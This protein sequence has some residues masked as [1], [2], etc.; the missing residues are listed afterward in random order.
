MLPL[1]PYRLG[2]RDEPINHLF[3]RIIKEVGR[4][5]D[6]GDVDD[7][8]DD[9]EAEGLR[10]SLD[11]L[12]CLLEDGIEIL[13]ESANDKWRVVSE[14][15][16]SV[17]G[18]E[19]VVLF[20]QPIETVTALAD[21]LDQKSGRRPAL[22]I[23]GQSDSERQAEVDAFRRP[24][25]PQF[26]VSSRA[27]GEGINLQVA[28]RLVHID[29]PWNPMDMEQRVGRVHR[30]GSRKTILVDTLVV[31]D[32]R[33]ADAYRISRQKLHLI[34][35]TLVAKD[36]FEQVFSRVMCL[37]PPEELQDVLL[38][39]PQ[40]PFN[41][42]EQERI[43]EMVQR[44]FH[45][46]RAFH[47]RFGMQ[48]REMRKQTP[49][50]MTWNDVKDFACDYLNAEKVDGFKRQRFRAS[51]GQVDAVEEDAVVLKL[52]SGQIVAC[53][54]AGGVPVYGP[55][56]S[57]APSVGLN[58]PPF[59]E[60]LRR[61]AFPRTPSGAAHLRW[62]EHIPAIWALP[63][64]VL[65]FLRQTIKAHHHGGWL[66]QG[67]CLFTYVLRIPSTVDLVEGPQKGQLMR[68]LFKATIRAKPGQDS[69]LM[70]LLRDQQANLVQQ[71]RRP[72]ESE[73]GDG[74]RHAVTPLLAATVASRE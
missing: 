38:N 46:W 3:A 69:D 43:A 65:V 19:K 74:V 64:G 62:P 15:L 21:Y 23:G 31:K 29:V 72:S 8:E 56:G 53:G 66:E 25:G 51:M 27:G 40:A 26:L 22:I 9:S 68:A 52:G 24:E 34:A 1:R 7:I 11:S 49:G 10:T 12:E 42:A 48:Q 60:T 35:T 13:N 2:P 41:V 39:A 57:V 20:A 61:L 18:D 5:H 45:T 55:G 67:H 58:L 32:S 33:E 6:D 36:R 70:I 71:L 59:A 54:E 28:R 17:A 63:F 37:V 44:G 50:L 14:E 16:L 73:I 47:E 4:Q 30:F